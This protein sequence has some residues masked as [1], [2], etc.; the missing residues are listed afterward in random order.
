MKQILRESCS[1]S[2][3]PF[4]DVHVE[5]MA[6]LNQI[7]PVGKKRLKRREQKYVIRDLILALCLCHNVTP[8]YPDESNPNHKEF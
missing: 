5:S 7:E 8:V 4:G 3:G 1:E 6:E 2:Q